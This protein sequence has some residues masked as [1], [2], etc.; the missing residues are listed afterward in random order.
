MTSS[1]VSTN[2][3]NRLGL[4]RRDF[5]DWE[6][7]SRRRYHSHYAVH[8]SRRMEQGEQ[9]KDPTLQPPPRI[10]DD[11]EKLGTLFGELNKYLRNMG[12]WQMY[13]GE[14]VVEPVLILF[15][16]A[17]LGFLGIQALGLVGVVCIVIIFIQK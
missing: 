12:F 17:M 2:V 14:R 16:W 10:V 9:T 1:T 7:S 5:E 15:F 3:S 13:F 4:H 11:C 8:Y 6:T